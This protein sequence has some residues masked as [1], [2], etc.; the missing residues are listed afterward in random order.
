[1]RRVSNGLAALSLAAAMAAAD[2]SAFGRSVKGNVVKAGSGT[3]LPKKKRVKVVGGVP[4][5]QATARKLMPINSN[6][7]KGLKLYFGK[8]KKYYVK[9]LRTKYDFPRSYD[10]TLEQFTA[11]FV[12][13]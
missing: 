12:V 7:E 11:D 5:I 9:Y 10:Y 1:M 6:E 4:E 2:L 8:K 13:V 3:A